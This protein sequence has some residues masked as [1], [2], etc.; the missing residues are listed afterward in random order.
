MFFVTSS[1]DFIVKGEKIQRLCLIHPKSK[2][3]S[4]F[5]VISNLAVYVWNI[6]YRWKQ[7]LITQFVC[8]SRDKSFKHIYSMIGQCLS[9]KNKST[10]MSKSKNFSNLNKACYVK[11]QKLFRSKQGL[12]LIPDE[13]VLSSRM[14]PIWLK[15]ERSRLYLFCFRW[16]EVIEP[17]GPP[18]SGLV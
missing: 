14:M 11:I 2:N 16:C 8:K 13:K 10:T 18:S 17:G 4:R 6:K 1:F 9:N 12:S 7:K 5:H 3:F 15:Y